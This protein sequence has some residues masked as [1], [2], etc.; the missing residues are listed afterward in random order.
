MI[1]SSRSTWK[2]AR[3]LRS[4]LVKLHAT[5]H[6][7]ILTFDH[8]V[9]DGWSHGV[10]LTELTAIYEAFLAGKPSSTAAVGGSITPDY[11]YWQQDLVSRKERS[12]R[13]WLI[14]VSNCG[15]M[16]PALLELPTDHPRPIEESFSGARHFLEL[17]KPLV[18]GLAAVGR[19]ENC[20]LFMVFLAAFQT[21]LAKYTE[22]DDI[23][24][25]SPIANRNRAETEALIGSFMNTVVL[26]TN[27]SGDPE[28]KELLHRVRKM[29]LDSYAHQDLPFEQLVADLQPTR[30]LGYSPVFQV[31]FI[32]QNTP[33]PRANVG[34]L[35]FQHFDVDAGT[36]KLDI[37]LNLEE[38]KDG[39]VGWIEYATDLFEPE[40][41]K[42]MAAHF[43]ELLR[44][45]VEAPQERLSKLRLAPKGA[46]WRFPAGMGNSSRRLSERN[47]DAGKVQ[48]TASASNSLGIPKLDLKPV[49][50]ASLT[51][52]QKDLAAIWSDVLGIQ[53]VAV[54]DNLFDLGG[55]S[56]L[57][58]RIISRIRKTFSVEIPIHTFFETPT[59]GGIATAIETE[60]AKGTSQKTAEPGIQ[61][62]ARR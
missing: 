1:V 20:T 57:I 15:R 16:R 8:I 19:K 10:F 30:N 26:R 51:P 4:G 60:K 56:L 6:L 2:P 18:D 5:D 62:L 9:I 27:L 47:E 49:L 11:A 40:S 53:D 34:K 37:T 59:L 3:W 33:M 54:D 58:T 39:A 23:I 52:V 13:T 12:N 25:G 22:R 14:G 28:F 7:L 45:I 38:T 42:N 61:R 41:I 24:I 17:E 43:K 44:N 48:S 50:P 36:S 21:L 55:H 46:E 31:M 29:S 32:L 35:S